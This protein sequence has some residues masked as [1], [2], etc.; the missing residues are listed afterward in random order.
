MLNEESMDVDYNHQ[1]LR[2]IVT[3]RDDNGTGKL[4]KVYD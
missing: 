3:N 2:T 4:N 1:R